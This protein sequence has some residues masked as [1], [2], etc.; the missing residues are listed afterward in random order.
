MNPFYDARKSHTV[1][2]VFKGYII[3]PNGDRPKVDQ[4]TVPQVY[5]RNFSDD[6]K[7]IQV[8]ESSPPASWVDFFS[9]FSILN[10]LLK[11]FGL[12]YFSVFLI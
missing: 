1:I 7:H 5:L 8:L 3:M 9:G 11:L 6:K 12:T 2:T 4:H 10:H